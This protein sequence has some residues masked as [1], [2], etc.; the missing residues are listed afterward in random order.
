MPEIMLRDLCRWDRRL[1]VIPPVGVSIESALDRGVSWA[2]SVR[3]APPLLPPLRGEEL[4]VLPRRVLEQIELGETLTRDSLLSTLAREQIAAILT[5]P[6]F[7]EV[8]IEQL[9][10]LTLP[11]PFPHDAEG[12][13]NRMITERRAELYR[14][15]AELSRRLSQAT[16]D[17][18]GISALLEIATEMSGRPFLL[19]DSDGNVVASSANEPLPGG[20]RLANRAR[21]VDG[22]LLSIEEGGQE[23]L[24]VTLLAAG[25]SGYLS[26]R[27]EVG[28]LTESDR[29]V[30]VQTAGLCAALLGQ[31][32]RAVS[33]DRGA[34]ERQVA[35]LLHGRLATSAATLARGHALGIGTN[36]PVSVGLIQ[37]DGGRTDMGQARNLISRIFGGSA[38]DNMA[39]VDGT[40][41]MLLSGIDLESA[42]RALKLALERDGAP[43]VSISLSHPLDTVVEAPAGVREAR[44]ALDLRRRGAIHHRVISCSSVDD[45]GVYSLLFPLWGSP[46]L[47]TF[48]STL[49]GQLEAYDRRR[50]SKLI[51][52]LEAYLTVGGAL[53]EAAEIVGIH[54]NTLS[55]RLQRI[56]E[57][58]GRNL[59]DP[60]ERLLLQVA[61]ATRH[62]PPVSEKS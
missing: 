29:L 51:T 61:L 9:P 3:A 22:Q 36:G 6:G 54:R 42:R 24:I 39:P 11:S 16:V 43:P 37:A 52:T 58:T 59:S 1:S 57:L 7:T 33:S 28:S 2:V 34:R 4:V 60:H 12:T 53:S 35:D 41:G 50:K 31:Q 49:L 14:L 13:L 23:Y 38:A 56:S 20:Q 45:L 25:R 30:L 5:E 18:R 48:R 10:V 55:Y 26:I 44:F 15:G 21:A 32:P 17:P 47:E 8:S 19:E 62:M 46:A 40:I 27:G